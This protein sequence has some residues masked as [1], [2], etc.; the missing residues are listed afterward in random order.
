M[1]EQIALTTYIEAVEN[2]IQYWLDIH[3]DSTKWAEN[4]II[5]DDIH[6]TFK[7]TP[8][9]E[10]NYFTFD[11]RESVLK[12]WC[13]DN[14]YQ[15]NICKNCGCYNDGYDCCDNVKLGRNPT[16][17]EL[18]Q[19]FIDLEDIE[20]MFTE[21]Q[22]I[23]SLATSGFKTYR[24]GIKDIIAPVIS[25]CKSVLKSIRNAKTNQDTLTAILWGTRVFHVHGN[26]MADYADRCNYEYQDM[27][28]LIDSI[29]NNGL[30]SVFSNE[31]IKSYLQE[32]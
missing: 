4:W 20:Q 24:A 10:N 22:L 3:T 17:K 13:R 16:T 32:G 25:E 6:Y 21:S 12:I 27:Y 18:I 14:K 15:F 30:N 31:E 8:I 7:T 1:T 29:R 11:W 19:W 28:T 23:E 9:I 2:T 5:D 26:I